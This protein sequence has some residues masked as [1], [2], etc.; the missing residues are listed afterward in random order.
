MGLGGPFGPQENSI[1]QAAAT[2]AGGLSGLF[3][4]ALPAMYQLK[5][6]D[7]PVKDF[8]RILTL[9]LVCSFFGICMSSSVISSLEFFELT[10]EQSSLHLSGSSL[11]ID[12]GIVLSLEVQADS[13][14][15]FRLRVSFASSSPVPQLLRL[16]SV[17][18]TLSVLLVRL[19]L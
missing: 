1:V 11:C 19:M 5:L 18:C 12:P 17:P 9:T 8:G 6:L 14:I 4:A 13:G 7:D 2:G 16:P 3:V 10:L 15:V